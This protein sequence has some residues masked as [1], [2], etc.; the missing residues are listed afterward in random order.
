MISD[1]KY[2]ELGQTSQ[3]MGVI[4]YK[5]VPLQSHAWVHSPLS[6]LTKSLQIQGFTFTPQF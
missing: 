5:T 1:T 3:L 4:L 6:L 2:L